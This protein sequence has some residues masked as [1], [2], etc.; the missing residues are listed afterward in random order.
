[1]SDERPR[2]RHGEK[3]YELLPPDGRHAWLDPDAD[4]ALAPPPAA[5]PVGGAPTPARPSTRRTIVVSCIA[6]FVAG[7]ATF[8]V[9]RAVRDD[10]PRRPSAA[11]ATSAP[12]R[13]TTPTTRPRATTTAPASNRPSTTAPAT[14]APATTA[15][16]TT[17]PATSTPGATTAPA[18][19]PRVVLGVTVS[20]GNA[21]VTI[22]SIASGS[23]ADAADLRAGD[24][25][26]SLDGAPIDT[27][28][29]LGAAIGARRAGDRVSIVV[30]RDGADVTVTAT[31]GTTA[32]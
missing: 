23:G 11:P 12:A 6:A 19:G 26:V 31:L 3:E 20:E 17:A 32:D 9:V 29:D 7:I 24:V 30:R 27:T 2:L 28:D 18:T 15:P 13:T 1:M 21:G 16:R 4:P 14:S 22:V 10:G 25:F 5:E 8:A